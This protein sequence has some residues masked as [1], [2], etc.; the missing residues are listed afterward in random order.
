MFAPARSCSIDLRLVPAT[1]VHLIPLNAA[2][3]DSM[4]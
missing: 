1:A 4:L 3:L 2:R